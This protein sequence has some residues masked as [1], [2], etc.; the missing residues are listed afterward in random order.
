MALPASGRSR[1]IVFAIGLSLLLSVL[2]VRFRDVQPIWEI[3]LQLLGE[4]DYSTIDFV[5]SPSG[6]RALE[7]IRCG[8]SGS[9]HQ[10]VPEEPS[11]ADVLGSTAEALIPVAIVDHWSSGLL[12]SRGCRDGSL[13]I[14]NGRA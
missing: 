1:V 2:F 11:V 8:R 14:C 6:I 3:A 12:S 5:P 7:S 10:L 13:R 9:R 4:S